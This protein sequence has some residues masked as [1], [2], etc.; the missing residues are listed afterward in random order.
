V[1]NVRTT[2]DGLRPPVDLR[3]LTGSEETAETVAGARLGE[4]Q[5]SF[6][7]RWVPTPVLR[8]ERLPLGAR[9]PGPAV[10]EQQ[11]GTTLVDQHTDV[12]VDD[13]GNLI[14]SLKEVRGG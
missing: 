3:R 10:I 14:L 9:F 5:V 12:T 6:A 11:D 4:R 8:R 7:G 1:V 2:V 13:F